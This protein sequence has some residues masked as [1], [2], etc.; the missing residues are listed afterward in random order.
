MM[1]RLLLLLLLLLG[2]ELLLG[3][4]DQVRRNQFG[5]AVGGGVPG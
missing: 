1:I 3:R 2:E 5:V 4:H